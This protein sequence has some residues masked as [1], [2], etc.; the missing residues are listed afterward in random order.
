MKVVAEQRCT[1]MLHLSKNEILKAAKPYE[2]TYAGIAGPSP[3]NMQEG[4]EHSLTSID[5]CSNTAGFLE[6]LVNMINQKG[7]NILIF[8]FFVTNQGSGRLHVIFFWPF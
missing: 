5:K 6:Y 4:Y 3:T 1:C 2:Y 7:C 8:E